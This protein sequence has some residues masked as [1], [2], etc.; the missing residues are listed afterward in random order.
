LMSPHP[1]HSH[2]AIKS[3][4]CR[5]VKSVLDGRINFVYDS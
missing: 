1:A 4:F 2:P 5:G 3:R